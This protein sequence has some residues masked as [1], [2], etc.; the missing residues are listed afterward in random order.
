ME[1][2]INQYSIHRLFLQKLYD[3]LW[4]T[5]LNIICKQLLHVLYDVISKILTLHLP[6]TYFYTYQNTYLHL[7]CLIYLLHVLDIII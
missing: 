6:N 1:M 4:N 7:L 5:L 2:Y 3:S